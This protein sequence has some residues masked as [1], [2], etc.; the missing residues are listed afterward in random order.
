MIIKTT[1]NKLMLSNKNIIIFGANGLIGSEI[2]RSILLNNGNVVAVD[3]KFN[4][5]KSKLKKIDKN[6]NNISIQYIKCDV[7]KENVIKNIIMKSTKIDGVVNCLYLKNKNWGRKFESVSRK[8][9]DENVIINLSTTFLINKYCVKKFYKTSNKFSLINFAS[10]YGVIPPKFNIYKNTKMTSPIEYS[11]IKS[12][13]I[14]L[15]KYVARYVKNSNFKCNCISPGGI[16][17]DHSNIFKKQYAQYTNGQ[18]MLKPNSLSNLT[19]FLLSE[20]SD[21]INGQNIIID[22]GFTL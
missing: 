12:S 15:T 6:K 22:D 4:N 1:I 5:L 21:F 18:G 17:D 13:T 9:F 11:V 10:I 8:D 2:T 19:I 7:L 14:H 16:E 3:N 20:N